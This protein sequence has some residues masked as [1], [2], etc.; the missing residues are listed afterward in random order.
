MYSVIK[1][2]FDLRIAEFNTAN[3]GYL[4]ETSISL[5]KNRLPL[6][7]RQANYSV[8]LENFSD[9]ITQNEKYEVSGLV[10]LTFSMVNKGIVNYEAVQEYIYKLARYIRRKSNYNPTGK[11]FGITNI[12][13]DDLN[14]VNEGSTE[15]NAKLVF[16]GEYYE[17]NAV[18]ITAPDVPTLTSPVDGYSSG[19]ADQNFNWESVTG[20]TSYTFELS[21]STGI[22]LTQGGLV[23]SSFTVPEDF[24]LSNGNY[25]WRVRANGEG[26][27]SDWSGY[28]DLTV[29][30]DPNPAIPTLDTP[31]NGATGTGTEIF[32]WSTSTNSTSYD[33]QIASDSGFNTIVTTV[34]G[35]TKTYYSYT[36]S[37]SGTYYW[38]V[39]GVNGLGSSSWTSGRS[40]VETLAIPDYR[41]GLVAEW[42]ADTGVTSDENGVSAWVDTIS[43]RSATQ[44]NNTN[45]PYYVMNAQNGKPS[46]KFSNTQFLSFSSL[47]LTNYTIIITYKASSFSAG[48]SNYMFAGSGQGIFSSINALSIGYGEFDGSRI[49]AVTYS[50]SDTTWHIRSFQNQKLYSNGTEATY[51]NTQNMTG[52]T[53]THIGTRGDNTSLAFKGQIA[54]IRV[55]GSVLSTTNRGIAETYLNSIYNIY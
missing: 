20:A 40:V 13:G 50:G 35:L 26:G 22:V 32:R 14:N 28:F 46:L 49:R 33:I 41:T 18:S 5:N 7:Q 11:H 24:S 30:D 29:N 3:S 6:N 4:V 1:D 54:N 51:S 44:S 45:K 48:D 16:E 10:E 23:N 19:L 52:L 25:T 2:Y 37:A 39:R 53:L 8:K 38:R 12:S 42:V 17:S 55:Y 47:A 21:D 36:F 9:S 43:G 15:L 34:T 31:A 27:S